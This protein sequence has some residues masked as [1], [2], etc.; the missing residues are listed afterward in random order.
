MIQE[1]ST[2]G[3]YQPSTLEIIQSALSLTRL[4]TENGDKFP[5]RTE[6]TEPVRRTA[7][8][9]LP[10]PFLAL[11]LT[12]NFYQMRQ[13]ELCT[14][15]QSQRAA[16]VKTITQLPQIFVSGYRYIVTSA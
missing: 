9:W 5:L 12:K 1:L 13:C 4:P 15:P 11:K 6:V 7:P 14:L 10:R 2:A 16:A 8:T 3:R